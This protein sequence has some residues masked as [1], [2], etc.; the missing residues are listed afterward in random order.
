MEG[1]STASG[2]PYTPVSSSA[3]WAIIRG[4][5]EPVLRRA[6]QMRGSVGAKVSATFMANHVRSR[7]LA[8]KTRPG[9]RPSTASTDP[10]DAPAFHILVRLLPHP[11]TYRFCDWAES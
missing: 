5:P 9:L 8:K 11:P 3:F 1:T 2:K 4:P 7:T 6:V 10:T